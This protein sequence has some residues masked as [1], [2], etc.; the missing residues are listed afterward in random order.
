[1]ER[2]E[3]TRGRAIFAWLVAM[4]LIF[5]SAVQNYD[6]VFSQYADRYRN[7]SW[8]SREMGQVI[9]QFSLTY[10]SENAW[11]VP[12]PHWVDTR[13]PAFWAGMP[14][15]GDM[16][17]WRDNLADTL[18]LSGTKLFIVKANVNMPEANDQE[19]LDALQEIYPQGLLSLYRSDVQGHD[20]WIYFVPPEGQ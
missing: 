10:G 12:F 5:L 14:E 19:T 16:A 6:L 15:R 8:N 13:L 18:A 17:M 7:S 9:Q 4:I 3:G 20:F 1:M 2:V 11:V